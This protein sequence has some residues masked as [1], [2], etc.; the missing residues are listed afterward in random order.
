MMEGELS[1]NPCTHYLYALIRMTRNSAPREQRLVGTRESKRVAYLICTDGSKGSGDRNIVPE[2]LAVLREAEQRAAAEVLGVQEIEFLGRPDQGLED[3]D[4]FRKDLVRAIRKY[5]PEVVL[6]TDP[7]RRYI[8]HRDHRI[9]GQVALDAVFPYARDHLAYPDLLKQGF[10]PHK[11]REMLFWGADDVNHRMDI[12]D[13]FDIKLA[14]LRCHK[15]QIIGHESEAWSEWLR[16]RH[17]KMAENEPY[18]LAEAFHRVEI[19]Y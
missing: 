16:S 9:T 1:W 7:Y 4:D 6:T 3:A 10:E 5:R 15:S 18:E 8:W 17:R 12:T 2:E 19:P 13:F 11:V 14:A